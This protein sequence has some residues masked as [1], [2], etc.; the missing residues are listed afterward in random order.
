[1]L[2]RI[3]DTATIL[4][5]TG[6]IIAGGNNGTG[7]FTAPTESDEKFDQ[8]AQ[9]HPGEQFDHGFVVL[10]HPLMFATSRRDLGVS[11]T[12]K[13]QSGNIV[14]CCIG[15]KPHSKRGVGGAGGY[16][17]F[18]VADFQQ[19]QTV[20]EAIGGELMAFFIS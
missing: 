17:V 15:Q 18:T 16:S 1:M 5:G 2:D 7:K 6:K 12:G 19:K 9:F 14:L 13:T 8:I 4:S 11:L 20:Y 3:P 10:Q